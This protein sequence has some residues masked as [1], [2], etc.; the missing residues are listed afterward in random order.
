MAFTASA[1][2]QKLATDLHYA[3]LPDELSKKAAELLGS[4]TFE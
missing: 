1:D 4:V 2:G 3:P